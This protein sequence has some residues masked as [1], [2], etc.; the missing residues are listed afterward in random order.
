MVSVMS[1]MALGGSDGKESVCNTGESGLIPGSERSSEG[2]GNLLQYSCLGNPMDGG[3]WRAKV[4]SDTTGRLTHT[5]IH[6]HTYTHDL[7]L[8]SE[9]EGNLQSFRQLG[10]RRVRI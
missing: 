8:P 1:C 5:H 6:T 4:E 2:N 10:S 3:A 9:R 7:Y